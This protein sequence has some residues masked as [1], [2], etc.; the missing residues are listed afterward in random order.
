MDTPTAWLVG[1]IGGTNVRL[2][3]AHA[4]AQGRP[5]LS[6][7]QSVRA[8]AFP[9]FA[10]ACRHYLAEVKTPVVGAVLSVAGRVQQRRV[11]M[12]NLPWVIDADE[13]ERELGLAQVQLINDLAAAAQS[14]PAL[15]EAEAPLLWPSEHA[16][17]GTERRRYAVLGAG[18]GLGM[19]LAVVED[20]RVQVLDTE[21]GHA[22]YAPESAEEDDVARVLRQR[23]GRV[24]WERVASGP[25]LSNLYAALPGEGAALSPEDILDRSHEQRCQSALRL[26]S[27]ALAAAAGDAVLMQGAWDGVYLMGGLLQATRPWI[28]G[29][30]FR[31]RFTAKGSFAQALQDVPVRLIEHQH[32]VLL[33]AA[34]QALSSQALACGPRHS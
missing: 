20:G 34:C 14:L 28:A 26:Y 33:G 16:A 15:S 2:A 18:T 32:P 10:E 1:D 19:A 9:S 17:T 8:A 3:L 30:A 31:R 7:V 22:A 29:Q 21:G 13:L 5:Q 4:D 25:G 11:S 23:F 27:Q 24:T 6:Q 12:T